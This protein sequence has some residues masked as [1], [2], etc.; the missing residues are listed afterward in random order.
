MAWTRQ[1]AI[2]SKCRTIQELDT[3][4]KCHVHRQDLCETSTNQSPI[5][6]I[7]RHTWW[8]GIVLCLWIYCLYVLVRRHGT[9]RLRKQVGAPPVVEGVHPSRTNRPMCG[10]FTFIIRY[11]AMNHLRSKEG[12]LI[13]IEINCDG[14]WV[15]SLKQTV[16][17][18]DH[19][20]LFVWD[21]C[22]LTF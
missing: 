4:F 2:V 15:L 22:V 19:A 11:Y 13:A 7:L 8:K 9:A 18:G 12:L 1:I 20:C 3:T 10:W 5:F 14:V 16:A 21:L 17:D 6:A